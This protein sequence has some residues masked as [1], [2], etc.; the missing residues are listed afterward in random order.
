MHLKSD[1]LNNIMWKGLIIFNIF[2]QNIRIRVKKQENFVIFYIDDF[3][4][5]NIIPAD[6]LYRELNSPEMQACASSISMFKY[7]NCP[8]DEDIIKVATDYVRTYLANYGPLL[9]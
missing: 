9:Q 4:G 1:N 8:E 3:K 5:E 6:E 7:S 2:I